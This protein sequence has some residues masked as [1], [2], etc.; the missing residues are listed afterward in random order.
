[1]KTKAQIVHKAG[2]ILAK[3]R[4]MADVRY[5]RMERKYIFII[6]IQW[7]IYVAISITYVLVVR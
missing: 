2:L 4:A 1:M 3:D 6:V 7:V 5:K